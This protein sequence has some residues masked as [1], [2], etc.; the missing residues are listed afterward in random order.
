MGQAAGQPVSVNRVHG[1][2]TWRGGRVTCDAWK[3]LPR[4]SGERE[5]RRRGLTCRGGCGARP[6]ATGN[7]PLGGGPCALRI[8]ESGTK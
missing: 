2:R 7:S 1:T 6:P 4:G 5:R 8:T 3:G